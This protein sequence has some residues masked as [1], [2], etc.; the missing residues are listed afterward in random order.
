[1]QKKK[2]QYQKLDNT[3][4]FDKIIKK[5]NYSKSNP[6]YDAN[7]SF[8]RYY[9]DRKKFG[10]LSSKSKD[11]FLN[12]FFGDLDKLNNLNPQ[13][14]SINKR[15]INVYDKASELYNDFPGI[16]HHKYFELQNDKRKKIESNC[17]PEDL[18]LDGYDYSVWSKNEEELTDKVE[19]EDLPLMLPLEGDGGVKQDK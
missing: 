16:Y 9:C 1:M 13:K 18:F 7:H 14:E 17:D 15:K 12:E 11:S 10:N 4:E 8:Y 5:E 19:S 2:K 3:Y 6:I